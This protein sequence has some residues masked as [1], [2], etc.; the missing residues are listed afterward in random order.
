VFAAITG[1]LFLNEQLNLVQVIG[2]VVILGA[3]LFAQLIVLKQNRK[4]L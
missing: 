2:C 1:V 3:I 4:P